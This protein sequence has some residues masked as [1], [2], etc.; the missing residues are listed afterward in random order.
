[1]LSCGQHPVKPVSWTYQQSPGSPVKEII[2][3]GVVVSDVAVRFSILDSSLII[4]TVEAHDNG[5]Y[6]CTDTAGEFRSIH[7]TVIGKLAALPSV[8]HC[9][10]TIVDIMGINSVVFLRMK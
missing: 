3:S 10:I 2:T 9:V 8:K 7:F 4:N 6:K 5:Y 1:M